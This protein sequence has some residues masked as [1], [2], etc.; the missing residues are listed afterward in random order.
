[1]TITRLTSPG[2]GLT[3]AQIDRIE[4]WYF[5]RIGA[6]TVEEIAEM[7]DVS[8]RH[9]QWAIDEIMRRRRKRA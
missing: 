7:L 3:C 2:G 8:R 9:V 5:G 4:G 6:E 1:M